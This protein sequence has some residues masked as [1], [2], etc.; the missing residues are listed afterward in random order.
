MKRLLILI[1]I[2][3]RIVCIG[4]TTL[5]VKKSNQ[6]IGHTEPINCLAYSPDGTVIASGSSFRSLSDID[7]GRFEII[8]WDAKDGGMLTRLLGHKD[9]IQSIIFNKSGTKIFSSDSKGVIKIWDINSLREIKSFHCDEWADNICLNSN[10]K[11]LFAE[12][13]FAKKVNIWK[14]ETGELIT[15]LDAKQQIN[16][17]DIS[18]QGDK[19]VLSCS[20]QI[21]IW[22]LKTL[23]KI[24]STNGD[25]LH[26]LSIKY[27]PSGEEIVTGLANGEIRVYNSSNLHLVRTLEGHFK[28][29]LDLSFNKSGK[30]LLSGSSDQMIKLWDY[31]KGI[32]IKSLTNE[33]KG[34]VKSVCF[35]PIDNSF[36]S[37]GDDK[38][39]IMWNL[40]K[41]I[42]SLN[43]ENNTNQNDKI[44][45]KDGIVLGNKI[46][47]INACTRSGKN[48]MIKVNGIDIDVNKF[49]SCVCDNLFPQMNSEEIFAIQKSKSIDSFLYSDKSW[50]VIK[51]CIMPNMKVEDDFKFEMSKKELSFAKKRLTNECV[52][53]FY[54]N[55]D[56]KE[57]ISTTLAENYCSC[58]IDKLYSNGYN[59]KDILDINDENSKAYN[60]ILLACMNELAPLSESKSN[61][62]S[63]DIKGTVTSS[64]IPLID[65][66]GSG[67]KIKISIDGVVKYFLFDTGASDILIDRDTERELLLNGTLKRENYLNKTQYILANN[68]IVNAQVVLINNVKV[69]DYLINN[70]KVA[71]LDKGDLLCGKSFLD[72]FK[73]WEI[74]K[75]NKQLILYK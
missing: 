27:N 32:E 38:R 8:L 37:A 13:P 26:G 19:I 34:T 56:L 69:G 33:H 63:S 52:T 67:Y 17:M 43:S 50:N 31:N 10:E 55:N 12:M 21:Q 2:F 30:Y 42:E 25:D 28:P 45:S 64:K 65:Y 36:S 71:I 68:Q 58:M 3:L 14:I 44:I 5:E 40:N 62:N 73:K 20:K 70:V 47:F 6:L 60:E 53:G 11:Y 39:I 51:D 7:S 54:K 24:L 59:Y 18:P 61:V 72:K 46:E 48:G 9:A 75:V 16:G 1:S 66:F 23:S 57:K 41:N 35:S 29:V 15:S 22:G 74:D 4:Q 49:C